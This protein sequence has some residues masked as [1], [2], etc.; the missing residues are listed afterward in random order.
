[1]TD[2]T[3]PTDTPDTTDT[4]GSAMIDSRVIPHL[5]VKGAADAIDFYGRAFGAVEHDD[6][7]GDRHHQV[8]VMLDHQ[9]RHAALA[10]LQQQLAQFTR[11]LAAQPQRSAC[12]I[13]RAHV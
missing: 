3:D 1:M 4:S 11:A 6:V 12:Q 7:V 5:I 8:H 13:G 2:T 10:D 9:D